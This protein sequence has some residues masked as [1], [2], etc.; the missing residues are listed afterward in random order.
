MNYRTS[1][2]DVRK[3]LIK[4]SNGSFYIVHKALSELSVENESRHLDLEEVVNKIHELM[5]K[6]KI[7][8]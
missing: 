8:A 4:E 1:S 7:P 3:R 2:E 6:E 5:A